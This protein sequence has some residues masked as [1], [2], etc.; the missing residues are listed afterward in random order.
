M[1]KLFFASITTLGLYF[2]TNAQTTF[3]VHVNGI[4]ASVNDKFEEDGQTIE[5]KGQGRISWKVGGVAIVPISANFSFMPQL[6]LLSKGTELEK[7]YNETDAG[8]TFTVTVDAIAKFTYLELPLNLVYNTSSF[9]VGAGPSVSYGVGGETFAKAIFSQNGTVV[10]MEESTHDV[11][12]DGNE[13]SNDGKD[14]FKPFEL[15]ANFLAGYKFG[16]GLFVNVHY[17]M[18]LSNINLDESST[19]R[20]RYFGVGVGYLFAK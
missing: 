3:G 7:T 18:G 9:F 17:N 4:S 2:I 14:H 20:N 10:A 5:T 1:K 19:T 6:N 16:N 13:N 8:Q 12:F 11:K 15:G